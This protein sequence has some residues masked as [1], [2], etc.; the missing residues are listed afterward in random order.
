MTEKNNSIIG[1]KKKD[2]E[3]NTSFHVIEYLMFYLRVGIF[4]FEDSKI[5]GRRHLNSLRAFVSL[6]ILYLLVVL[7]KKNP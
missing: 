5:I 4:F 2:I 7:I 1:I 3:R 6:E